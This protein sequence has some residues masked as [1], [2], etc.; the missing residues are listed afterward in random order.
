[1]TLQQE[2]LI[3]TTVRQSRGHRSH[4]P[5]LGRSGERLVFSDRE[6]QQEAF[7][8]AEVVVSDGCVVL[9]ARRVQDVD[10]NF[11]AVQHHLF[12]IAVGLCRLVVLYKLR[13]EIAQKDHV[14]Q[15]SE[16]A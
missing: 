10:L 1:M 7:A 13:V 16:K 11:L 9:L 5:E 4:T 8:A 2:F 3:V 12:P 15:Y 6:H 14:D